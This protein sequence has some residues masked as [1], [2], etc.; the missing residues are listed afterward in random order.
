MTLKSWTEENT[1]LRRVLYT[2]KKM[3]LVL[4]AVQPG[5]EIGEE[6]HNGRDQFFRV[7][8][9]QGRNLDRRHQDQDYLNKLRKADVGVGCNLPNLLTSDFLKAGTFASH[10]WLSRGSNCRDRC[11][12]RPDR[13]LR[14]IPR[15]TSDSQNRRG[16]RRPRIWR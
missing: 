4:M 14:V 16:C 11:Q 10:C 8:I 9:R 5:E 6:V 15:A 1:D 13:S 3:Q 12:S 2:A 7:E